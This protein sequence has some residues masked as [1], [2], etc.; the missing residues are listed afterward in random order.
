MNHRSSHKHTSVIISFLRYVFLD[1]M[2]YWIFLPIIISTLHLCRL[3]AMCTTSLCL[4]SFQR[5]GETW[6]T[7]LPRRYRPISLLCH[8]Y[9]LFERMVLNPITE[10]TIIEEKAAFR[11]GKSCTRQLLNLTH[12]TIED[13]HEKVLPLYLWTCLLRLIL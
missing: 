2:F 9:K 12:Y 5:C 10:H 13:G 6:Q 1:Q 3:V 4:R 8:M 7:R 11:T